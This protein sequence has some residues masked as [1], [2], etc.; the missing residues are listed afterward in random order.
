MYVYFFIELSIIVINLCSI[1]VSKYL[2]EFYGGTVLKF[3]ECQI[4]RF[5]LHNLIN[6]CNCEAIITY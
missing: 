3:L 6:R 5:S 2:T 1:C 4:R